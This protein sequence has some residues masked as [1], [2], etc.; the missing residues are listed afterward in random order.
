MSGKT[1]S[2]ISSKGTSSPV[3]RSFDLPDLSKAT[4]KISGAKEPNFYEVVVLEMLVDILLSAERRYINKFATT[5][6]SKVL[7]FNT[8]Y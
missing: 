1:R 2:T 5:I 3:K 6:T 4:R 7:Q 8:I